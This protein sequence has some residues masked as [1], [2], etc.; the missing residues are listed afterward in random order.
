MLKLYDALAQ[1]SNVPKGGGTAFS[2]AGVHVTP[3]NGSAIFW[4]T[5]LRSGDVNERTW[6]GACSVIFGEKTGKIR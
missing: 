4:P 3:K 2:Q 5:L 6:H 1:L